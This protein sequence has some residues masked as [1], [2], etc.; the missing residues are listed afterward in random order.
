MGSEWQAGWIAAPAT[1]NDEVYISEPEYR[2]RSRFTRHQSRW[3]HD[4]LSAILY[5]AGNQL[6][7][8]IGRAARSSLFGVSFMQVHCTALRIDCSRQ[9]PP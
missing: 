4:N 1:R 6:I 8:D 5:C 7:K 3:D 2:R 9:N